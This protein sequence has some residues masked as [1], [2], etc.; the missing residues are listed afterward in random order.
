MLDRRHLLVGLSALGATGSLPAWAAEDVGTV[1]VATGTVTGRR[2]GARR[3]LAPGLPLYVGERLITGAASRL[4]AALG[5]ATRLYMGA[6]TRVEIDRY[7]VA[8]GGD[9]R[10]LDGALALDREE[11]GQSQDTI[12]TSPYALLAVRGTKLFA[13]PSNG[14]FG[15]FVFTGRVDVSNRAGRVT[16][17]GGQGTNIATPGAAPTPPGEWKQ[18]RI[19]AAWQSVT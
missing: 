3:E 19:D 11:P 12:I 2:K 6:N 8:R 4:E 18:P 16:L 13:G 9:I 7:M 14:V 15:V 17:T 1:A 10:L 5:P